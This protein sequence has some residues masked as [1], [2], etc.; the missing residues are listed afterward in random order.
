MEFLQHVNDLNSQITKNLKDLLGRTKFSVI[1]MGYFTL[2][3]LEDNWEL[4]KVENSE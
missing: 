2:K 4:F 1:S 3:G